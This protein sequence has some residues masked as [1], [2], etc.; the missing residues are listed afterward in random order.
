[1]DRLVPSAQAETDEVSH[2]PYETSTRVNVP[3]STPALAGSRTKTA[4]PRPLSCRY[5][6][7]ASVIR[8]EKRVGSREN[9]FC[10][11]PWSESVSVPWG[12]E[13]KSAPARGAHYARAAGQKIQ[14]LVAAPLREARR[15]SIPS[16]PS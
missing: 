10:D 9:P 6:P 13:R 2:S 15:R 1:M 5:A 16:H 4:V 3:W 14:A 8:N 7:E 11:G 12:V